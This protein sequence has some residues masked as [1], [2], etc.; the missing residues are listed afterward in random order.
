MSR[1]RS[2]DTQPELVV[3]RA[4]FGLGYR[5]RLHDKRLPGRPDLVFWGR[6]K[7]ILVNGCFWHNHDCGRV[8]IPKANRGYWLEKLARNGLRDREQQN[9]LRAAG[10]AVLVVWECELSEVDR[11]R[12]RI[13]RFLG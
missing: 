2:A 6:R 7:V 8:R 12:R 13:K 4:A 11:L 3:R 9:W 1:I 5:Y 10:W